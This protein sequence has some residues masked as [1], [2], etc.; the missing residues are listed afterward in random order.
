VLLEACT[1]PTLKCTFLYDIAEF[2]KK[3][4]P[5]IMVA[6]DGT[7][8]SPIVIRPLECAFVDFSWHSATKYING[9][10]DVVMGLISTN[11]EERC[12]QLCNPR[13]MFK[14]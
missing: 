11:S 3:V 12:E 7:F 9:H 8:L 13:E 1:N 2:I 4:D 14:F 10:T 5:S 6:V